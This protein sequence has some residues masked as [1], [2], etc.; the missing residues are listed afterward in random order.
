MALEEAV[1]II[2]SSFF[3]AQNVFFLSQITETYCH[4]SHIVLCLWA[5]FVKY[6]VLLL[7]PNPFTSLKHV[8]HKQ[9]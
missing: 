9:M 6:V 3:S 4:L 5:V 7:S 2:K 8:L 1:L